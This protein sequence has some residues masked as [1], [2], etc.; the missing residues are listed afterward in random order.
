MTSAGSHPLR[1]GQAVFVPAAD[2]PLRAW[3]AGSFAQASVP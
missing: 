1:A 2:G 3:G